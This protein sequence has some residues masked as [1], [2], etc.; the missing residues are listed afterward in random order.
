MDMI[1]G[2][3]KVESSD[4]RR[5]DVQ[6]PATERV[7]DS[8]PAATKE[9]VGAAFENAVTGVAQWG[10]V[11]LHERIRVIKAFLTRFHA[12]RDEL[13]A[14][15]L[16]ETGKTQAQSMGCIYGSE[17]LAEHYVELA[18]TLGGETFPIGN[19]PETEGSIVLTV[20]EPLGIIVCILPYNFPIDSYMH[21]V[22][23][24]LLMGN[25][26]IVK[27]AS[28]TP[29]TDICVTQLL[30]DSGVPANT[31]QIIT[32]SGTK[33]GRWLTEDNRVSLVNL[34]GSTRVG[35]E[36]AQACAS[37][38]VRAHLE[39]GGNDPFVILP[40]ADVAQATV[41]AFNARIGN[42]GQVCCA[43]KRFIL[44]RPMK[45][46]FIEGLI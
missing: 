46:A 42:C 45:E 29:L 14:L 25:A 6:N 18:R 17:S 5:I 4:G 23:H 37:H 30:L 44:H 31:L 16:R 26:V 8:V 40:D 13:C 34:T 12:C 15:L 28:D 27:P 41:E 22:I 10:A 38:L 2:G 9:D 11:A 43:A 32:G 20:R 39:L 21:K 19:R 7:I 35:I 36:I 3:K 24:A 33:V 1:I